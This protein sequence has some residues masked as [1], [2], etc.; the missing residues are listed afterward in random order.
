MFKLSNV[1][2]ENILSIKSL[3]IPSE[4]ITCIVGKSGGGKTTFLKLLNN[5]ISCSNGIIK[6]KNKEVDKYDPIKLRREI[7]MLPQKPIVFAGTLEDNFKKTQFFTEQEKSSKERYQNILRKVHLNKNLQDKADNLSGGEKQRL[8]L[9]RILLLKPKILL[10]DEPSSALD[11]QTEKQIIEMVTSYINKNGGTLVMVTHSRK[12]A[13]TYGEK[14]V[15]INDGQVENV[16]TKGE[17]L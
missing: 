10:L 15:I 8:A 5:M 9:A 12:I 17:N 14:I 13:E 2:Y 16:I 7:V 1:T 3:N 4:A 11:D 6:F